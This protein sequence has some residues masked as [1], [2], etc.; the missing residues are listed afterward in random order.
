M[1]YRSVRCSSRR[2][3][4]MNVPVVGGR[5]HAATGR[6]HNKSSIN[7][8]TSK[9][10]Q[11][12]SEKQTTTEKIPTSS[13]SHIANA[14]TAAQQQSGD[15]SST[16]LAQINNEY[17][18]ELVEET[19]IHAVSAT[20]SRRL[21]KLAIM[22]NT[23]RRTLARFQRDDVLHDV[24]LEENRLEDLADSS[25]LLDARHVANQ[26]RSYAKRHRHR[27]NDDSSLVVQYLS[28][29]V[30]RLIDDFDPQHLANMVWAWATIRY[31]PSNEVRAAMEQ[32]MLTCLDEYYKPQALANTIWLWA[33]M[34]YQSSEAVLTSIERRMDVVDDFDDSQ[35]EQALTNTVWA[36]ATIYDQPSLAVMTGMERRIL[37]C[38]L[39]DFD[40]QLLANTVWAWVALRHQPSEAM[41]AAIEQRIMIACLDDFKPKH[42]AN[43]A[44]VW[45]S[46]RHQPPDTVLDALEWRMLG[47]ID[48]FDPQLLANT[49]WAFATLRY[50]P[51]MTVL[52]VIEQRILSCG[53]DDFDPQELSNILWAWTTI[54]H[55]PSNAVLTAIE[56]RMLACDID[57][58]MPQAL[59]NTVWA[60]AMLVNRTT[61][62]TTHA[63]NQDVFDRMLH[64]LEHYAQS[65]MLVAQHYEQVYQAHHL[66]GDRFKPSAALLDRSCKAWEK[67]LLSSQTL[68][69]SS[70]GKEVAAC[71]DRLGVKYE[72]DVVT[73][74]GMHRIDILVRTTA[75]D[76]TQQ[77]Q[78]MLAIACDGPEHFMRSCYDTYHIDGSTFARNYELSDL[79]F[80]VLCIA[81]HK[82]RM[83]KT[84]DERDN[85]MRSELLKFW[86]RIFGCFLLCLSEMTCDNTEEVCDTNTGEIWFDPRYLKYGYV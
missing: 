26:L 62:I 55:R 46:I 3:G 60:L 75:G 83:L 51:S 23:T 42:L 47:C 13:S 39:D 59:A 35:Q 8:R 37:A 38:C 61:T 5:R 43:M 33:T 50:Q 56:Q 25:S 29:Q 27:G 30:P 82:W 10:Q 57:D 22:H 64:R 20:M 52:A 45:A 69:Q 14:T 34:K 16:A 12:G 15:S 28:N 78:H 58:L 44:W 81:V 53:L 24:L 68:S 84:D 79:G 74:D 2:S 72:L 17:D 65:G 48:D 31:Q 21:A 66:L 63:V 80:D 4:L 1:L 6:H 54:R 41:L 36:W 70:F 86:C 7:S 67:S 77:Q 32:R 76:N 11:N 19:E 85:Y 73:E 9:R 49:L 40:P 71:L 18:D